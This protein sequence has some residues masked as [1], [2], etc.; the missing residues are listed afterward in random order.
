MSSAVAPAAATGSPAVVMGQ[1]PIN[2][3]AMSDAIP[4]DTRPLKPMAKHPISQAFARYMKIG[5]DAFARNV[6]LGK[7]PKEYNPR[8][9]GFYNPAVYYGKP[10]TPFS[11]VK[12]NEMGAWVKRREW[13]LTP[14]A[15]LISRGFWRYCQ[16]WVTTRYIS[17]VFLMHVVAINGIAAFFW[18]SHEMS[19]WHHQRYRYH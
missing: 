7:T 13:G 11:Q 9:H 5:F 15:R 6:E 18:K 1:G 2:L 16:T 12:L 8:V 10:D 14:T 3:T 19:H 17:S 4:V